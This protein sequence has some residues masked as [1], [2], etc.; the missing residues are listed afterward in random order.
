[1]DSGF[2]PRTKVPR[3]AFDYNAIVIYMPSIAYKVEFADDA[4]A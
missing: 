3:L 4:A 2:T 1:M